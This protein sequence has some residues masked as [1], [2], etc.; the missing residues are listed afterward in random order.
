MPK[1]CASDIYEIKDPNLQSIRG[2]DQAD[3]IEKVLIVDDEPMHIMALTSL[4]ET[5]GIPSAFQTSGVKAIE[6]LAELIYQK[7]PIYKV[8]IIDFCMK[9]MDGPQTAKQI[10]EL[11]NDARRK[12]PFLV[13]CSSNSEETF[14]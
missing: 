5:E 2:L 9:V 7:K 8:I 11:C 1:N 13:C 12:E 10:K 3:F 14:Q 6:H 4:L